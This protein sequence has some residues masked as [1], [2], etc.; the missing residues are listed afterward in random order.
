MNI[1]L[2]SRIAP[3]PQVIAQHLP[4]EAVLLL[5]AKGEVK[6]LNEV[7]ACIWAALD[8]TRTVADVIARVC[9]EYDVDREQAAQDTL[10]FV[11]ELLDRAMVLLVA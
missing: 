5:P 10:A 2:H 6:V 8:G 4:N 1:S 9:A 3:H 7:G 11:R